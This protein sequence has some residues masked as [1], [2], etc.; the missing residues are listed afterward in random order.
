MPERSRRIRGLRR[1]KTAEDPTDCQSG[2]S[3]VNR[4]LESHAAV[5]DHTHG[6]VRKQRQNTHNE[7]IRG[8]WVIQ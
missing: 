6:S 2:Q 4:L 7:T 8:G 5:G 1:R 3:S